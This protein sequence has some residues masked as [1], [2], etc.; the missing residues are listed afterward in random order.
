MLTYPV[1]ITQYTTTNCFLRP[2]FCWDVGFSLNIRN[3][4]HKHSV[5][6]QLSQ[7]VKRAVQNVGKMNSIFAMW[8]KYLN[9]ELEQPPSDCLMLIYLLEIKIVL[10]LK[11]TSPRRR[12]DLEAIKRRLTKKFSINSTTFI[13][14]ETFTIWTMYKE[15]CIRKPRKE[16]Q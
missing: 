2:C 10:N 6:T 9:V 3:F 7:N 4:L 15:K 13:M 12:Q 11:L 5:H 1:L 14:I 16:D 8:R